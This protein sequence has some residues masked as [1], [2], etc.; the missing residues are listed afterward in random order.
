MARGAANDQD[1]R[2]ENPP[3]ADTVDESRVTEWREGS[4]R[5][6]ETQG[7]AG[8]DVRKLRTEFPMLHSLASLTDALGFMRCLECR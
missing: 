8:E 1:Y 6:V 4:D 3:D 5:V 2:E 7:G